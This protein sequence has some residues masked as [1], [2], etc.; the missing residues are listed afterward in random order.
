MLVRTSGGQGGVP[1]LQVVSR[2]SC[3]EQR[4]GTVQEWWGR[5]RAVCVEES[6]GWNVA[7]GVG[8]GGVDSP[9]CPSISVAWFFIYS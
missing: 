7:V 1:E 6:W 8:W 3:L 2:I 4:L 5:K 9:V